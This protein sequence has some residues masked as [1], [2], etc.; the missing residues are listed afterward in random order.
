MRK[1]LTSA[2]ILFLAFQAFAHK[3][4][5]HSKE[6]QRKGKTKTHSKSK[7]VIKKP[8]LLQLKRVNLHYKEQ[9]KPI[10]KA[11]CWDCH[12]SG[13]DL[14]W[15]SVI[16]G[17]KQ[18]LESDLSDAKKHMDMSDDFPFKGHGSPKEDLEALRR[19]LQEESMPPFRY[20]VLHWGY[21]PTAVEEQKIHYWIEESMDILR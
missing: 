18:L 20:R 4:V 16:P 15:Y 19:M 14:P 8:T 6:G 11:K 5:D 10:F 13:N 7:P 12:G 17:I 21:L 9:V 2:A 1:I 3:G